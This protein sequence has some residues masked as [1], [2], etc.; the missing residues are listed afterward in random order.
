MVQQVL[1]LLL[2]LELVST[3][4][5]LLLLQLVLSALLDLLL[6][7]VSSLG[8]PSPHQQVV[9]HLLQCCQRQ[10]SA[11]SAS[12]ILPTMPSMQSLNPLHFEQYLGFLKDFSHAI[13]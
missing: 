10:L 13:P 5:L 4:W 6:P 7:P 2:V 9:G 11:D 3:L 1:E 12:T 8:S